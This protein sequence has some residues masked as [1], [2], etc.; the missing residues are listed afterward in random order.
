ME[1]NT[2]SHDPNHTYLSVG[3]S[4]P[5]YVMPSS[6]GR[7]EQMAKQK[8]RSADDYDTTQPVLSSKEPLYESL[9]D[10]S[11][12][13]SDLVPAMSSSSATQPAPPPPPPP[14]TGRPHSENLSG[15]AS[16]WPSGRPLPPINLTPPQREPSYEILDPV[17]LYDNLPDED[18]AMADLGN[19]DAGKSHL[20][21]P[22]VTHS[23]KS[24]ARSPQHHHL[25][26]P[27][28][29]TARS[30]PTSPSRTRGGSVRGT[31]RGRGASLRG[32]SGGT[33]AG[34]TATHHQAHHAQPQAHQHINVH[35]PA[36]ATASRGRISAR[37][38]AAARLRGSG[39][40]RGGQ[41]SPGRA[42]GAGTGGPIVAARQHSTTKIT[43]RSSSHSHSAGNGDHD[44]DHS[45]EYEDSLLAD[46]DDDDVDGS[47][48]SH[49]PRRISDI[50][51]AKEAAKVAAIKDAL[52][53]FTRSPSGITL[54]GRRLGEGYFGRVEEARMRTD[55]GK[56]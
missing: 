11:L 41:L 13:P 42:A 49:L 4:E 26:K 5:D 47:G 46:D 25:G 56:V 48:G 17:N 16:S 32:R 28:A 31:A 3:G 36:S 33:A 27:P 45:D 6:L 15:A 24:P 1:S 23:P 55:D 18:A 2:S 50:H 51:R 29:L 38:K 40:G 22:A 30:E 20:G 12:A 54:T 43:V 52:R 21:Y 53:A 37:G 44:H 7:L 39:R 34:T 9:G 10:G 35:A 19:P 14:R 8:V